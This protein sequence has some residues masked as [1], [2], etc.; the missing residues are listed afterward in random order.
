M[1]RD[2][3]LR[4]CVDRGVADETSVSAVSHLFYVFLLSALQRGQRVEI[5]D[6]GTFGTRLVGVK[7]SKKI[8]Y[9]EPDIDLAD[10]VNER[11]RELKYVVVGKFE[12]TELKVATGY[13]GKEA[14]HDPLVDQLGKEI[15]IDTHHEVTSSDAEAI[16]GRRKTLNQ[17]KE[18]PPMPKFNLKEG[19]T[20]GDTGGQRTPPP[21]LHEQENG[22]GPGPLVQVLIAVLILG[23]LT[24]ALHY[25]GVITLWGP[26]KTEQAAMPEP[27]PPVIQEE[28]PID[29]AAPPPTPTPVP[30]KKPERPPMGTG[31]Y[32]VQVSAWQSRSKADREV[33]RLTDAQLDAF[34]EE[35]TVEGDRWYR[36]RVGRYQT[37]SEATD[38]AARLGQVLEN[39]AW[40]TKVGG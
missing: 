34:V 12:E 39:G 27:L 17:P 18:K 22:K 21:T 11:Y 5:P 26:G 10:Q 23:L 28:M 36:V 4:K 20:E 40:V 9:F 30:V 29:T 38:A 35:G 16:L 33:A 19:A 31:D 3:L 6:F 24:L 8:P 14:P 15:I 25:F 2:E 1:T 32:T 13:S 7:R 37:Q